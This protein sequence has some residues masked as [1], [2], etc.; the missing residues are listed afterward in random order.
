MKKLE[1]NWKDLKNPTRAFRILLTFQNSTRYVQCVQF[2]PNHFEGSCFQN[3]SVFHLFFPIYLGS[4]PSYKYI[5]THKLTS[6][7]TYSVPFD[8]NPF[9]T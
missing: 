5:I 8:Y 9:N 1:G 4:H 3:L 7:E 2:I 6:N